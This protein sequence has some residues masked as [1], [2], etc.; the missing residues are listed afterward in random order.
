M[1]C[2]DYIPVSVVIPYFKSSE[3]IGRALES[4]DY[5]TKRPKEVVIVD[6]FSNDGSIELLR[7]I[8]RKFEDGWIKLIHLT[9][10]GGPG[11][12]RNIGWEKASQLYVAFLDAD[13]SWHP[14]KIET[15]YDWL[16]RNPSV[17]LLG[18]SAVYC[19]SEAV[20]LLI[21]NSV[22]LSPVFRRVTPQKLLFS[23]C[24]STPGVM[25]K[26]SIPLRF[27]TARRYVEDYDLW[28]RI[29]FHGYECVCSNHSHTFMHKYAYGVSGLSSNLWLM[30]KGELSV[31]RD[32]Y[33]NRFLNSCFYCFLV[34]C[35]MI[36]FFRRV[37]LSRFYR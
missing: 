20:Q 22:D 17:A 37:F 23:N 8:V 35:S 24:F 18:H 32:L 33:K 36:K 12:A 4:I 25:L 19:Q 2:K 9:E 5:Q 14:K 16:I 28:L 27:S 11:Q 15:Q 10:N 6:D 29:A 3:T 13:D 31:Y 26:R 30:Q 1:I 21:A 34:F 7:D